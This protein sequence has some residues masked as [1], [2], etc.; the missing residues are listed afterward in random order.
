MK[1]E[2]LEDGEFFSLTEGHRDVVRQKL[3]QRV[4]NGVTYNS[5]YTTGVYR[6][7]LA[8]ITGGTEVK[9]MEG[10]FQPR[11]EPPVLTFAD[12]KFGAVFNF[13]FKGHKEF[14]TVKFMR[15]G[16]Y[17]TTLGNAVNLGLKVLV[18]IEDDLEVRIIKEE[19]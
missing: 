2:D 4:V 12:L 16:R 3:R 6:G 10:A 5:C 7:Q 17:G 1:F 19:E 15:V 8:Y 18:E 14:G 9:V 13:K 11:K